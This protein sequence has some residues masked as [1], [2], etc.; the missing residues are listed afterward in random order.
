MLTLPDNVLAWLRSI[1]PDP[2]WG[3]V[4]LHDRL[5]SKAARA[6]KTPSSQSDAELVQ[7]TGKRA[8]IVVNPS[9]IRRLEGVSLIPLA[10]GRALIA[11]EPGKGASDLELAIVD[12]LEQL[13]SESRDRNELQQLRLSLRRWRQQEGLRFRTRSIIVV[14]RRPDPAP[15]ALDQQSKS[16]RLRTSRGRG[17]VG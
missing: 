12:R 15:A 8:L 1:H 11:L 16:I 14:E 6:S 5:A 17:I 2:A 3:I 7:L 13:D 4:T 10:D 9:V